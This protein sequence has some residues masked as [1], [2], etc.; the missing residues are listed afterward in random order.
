MTSAGLVII[1][2]LLAGGA[3][4]PIFQPGAPG[5]APRQISVE[6]SV[7]MSRTGHIDA[8]VRF[9]QHM[10]IHHAQAVDM[11]GLLRDR[12]ASPTVKLLGERIAISQASEMELMTGWLE[13]RGLPVEAADLH[14]EHDAPAADPHAAHH[15]KHEH[16]APATSERDT[17]VMPGMLSPAQMDAL[18]A[19]RGEAFDRLFLTGMIQHHQGALDMVAALMA[20]PNAA[21]ETILSEFVN[22]VVTDQ[23]AEILRMQSLLS[24]L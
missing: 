14:G 7:A 3:Q 5:A 2:S 21:E 10:I 19:A 4:P 24:E 1:V 11:V 17:P 22:S 16:D 23:S 18:A 20:E 12:G 6:K 15:G 13:A 9:M 8:D